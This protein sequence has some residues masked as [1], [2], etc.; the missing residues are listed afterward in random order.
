MQ[1]SVGLSDVHE[2]ID[3]RFVSFRFPYSKTICR[4]HLRQPEDFLP[5]LDGYRVEDEN[6][7]GCLTFS[8]DQL[9]CLQCC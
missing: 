4:N 6:G 5:L 3:A 7:I 9:Y 2:V 1:L 8:G